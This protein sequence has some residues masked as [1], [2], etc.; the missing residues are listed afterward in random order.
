VIPKT[1]RAGVTSQLISKCSWWPDV[2]KLKLTINERIRRLANNDE[3]E[4]N[5]FAEFLTNI[6]DGK[7]PYESDLGEFMIRI[8]DEF[9][10]QSPERE[11]F[12][13][14]CFPNISRDANVGNRAIL[15]PLNKDADELNDIALSK[16]TGVASAHLS[17]DSVSTSDNDEAMNYPVEF[18]NTLSLS[19][20]PAHDLKLKID[21]P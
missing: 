8:P 4:L 16:M 12:I 10:F 5:S 2:L 17:V 6:G 3:Q 21:V 1:N 11:D 15:T 18:L 19:G 13:D 20:M 14:W 9:V 7:V